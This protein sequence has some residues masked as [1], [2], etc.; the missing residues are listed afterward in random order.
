MTITVSGIFLIIF[1]IAMGLTIG[2]GISG[3]VI[4]L[5]I[6]SDKAWTQILGHFRLYD[7][8]VAFAYD[9]YRKKRNSKLE[10]GYIDEKGVF[11]PKKEKEG[12]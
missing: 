7:N 1:Y 3:L 5:G 12:D 4:I 6:L 2:I 8:L 11:H 9:R 10:N